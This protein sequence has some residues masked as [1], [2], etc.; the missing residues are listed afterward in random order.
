MIRRKL[1]IVLG[2]VTCFALVGCGA[3]NAPLNV[4]KTDD[5]GLPEL[6]VPVSV[7][8]TSGVFFGSGTDLK[9]TS[10]FIFVVNTA[11]SGMFNSIVPV[12][13]ADGVITE[14]N[15]TTLTIQHSSRLAS[16]ITNVGGLV[17][18]GDYVVRGQ[19]ISQQQF[20]TYGGTGLPGFVYSVLLDGRVVCPWSY[21]STDARNQILNIANGGGFAFN[22]GVCI[23]N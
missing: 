20:A 9:P 23:T 12:A 2:I 13:P 19:Q 7:L 4:L 21:F 8:N 16:K 14:L 5:E 3:T 22:Q 17:R 18:V 10:G 6:G 1:K 15:G 11:Y